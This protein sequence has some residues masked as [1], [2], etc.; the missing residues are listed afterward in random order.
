MKNARPTPVSLLALV[1]LTLPILLLGHETSA[2][3]IDLREGTTRHLRFQKV[4]GTLQHVPLKHAGKGKGEKAALRGRK[5]RKGP[6]AT[7]RDKKEGILKRTSSTAS[8]MLSNATNQAM[9]YFNGSSGNAT[10]A[11]GTATPITLP[12]PVDAAA[13]SAPTDA[14]DKKAP[15]AVTIVRAPIPQEAEQP[16]AEGPPTLPHKAKKSVG[17]I[18]RSPKGWFN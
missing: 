13:D 7:R 3:D 17:E 9:Q 18:L 1:L 6:L 11:N 15:E 2:G 5:D 12:D 16:D 14:T 4:N 8:A 10:A